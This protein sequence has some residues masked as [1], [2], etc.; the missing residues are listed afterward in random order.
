MNAKTEPATWLVGLII[1]P[2]PPPAPREGIISFPL[3]FIGIDETSLFPPG[4]PVNV[5]MRQI[6]LAA[7]GKYTL[8]ATPAIVYIQTGGVALLP[9]GRL[10]FTKGPG[11]N[12]TPGP[13]TGRPDTLFATPG[14]EVQIVGSDTAIVGGDGSVT[15]KNVGDRPAV[16]LVMSTVPSEV[17]GTATPAATPAA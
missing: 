13:N 14:A 17:G 15:I 5:T 8:D 12:A 6:G 11:E 4:G 2:G 9:T 10:S 1:P 16:L 3:G 7:G